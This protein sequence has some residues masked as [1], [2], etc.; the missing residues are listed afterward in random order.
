MVNEFIGRRADLNTLED[1]D[2]DERSNLLPIFGR[3]RIG[4][5]DK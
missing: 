1:K 4:K 2:A 5:S 3:R